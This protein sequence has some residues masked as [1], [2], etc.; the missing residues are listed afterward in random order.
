MDGCLLC[1]A[2]RRPVPPR[3]QPRYKYK[4]LTAQEF[5]FIMAF[6]KR[7]FAGSSRKG[8]SKRSKKMGVRRRF[9][10]G[11]RD[12]VSAT[13]GLKSAIQPFRGRKTSKRSYRNELWKSTNMM[14]HYRSVFTDFLVA[15]AATL[16]NS[17]QVYQYTMIP[18]DFMFITGGA[19]TPVIGATTWGN[20]FTI[21]GGVCT[22]H[23]TNPTTNVDGVMVVTV[24]EMITTGR[25][26]TPNP[27]LGLVDRAWDPSVDF[28]L[29][30]QFKIFKKHKFI[31]SIGETVEIQ[32]RQKLRKWDRTHQSV[33]GEFIPVWYITVS[34]DRGLAG[35]DLHV[36]RSHNISFTGDIVN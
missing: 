22:L 24:Y 33:N 18:T 16:R 17:A 35:R 10:R 13:N 2:G 30:D 29:N 23:L 1:I 31:I 11:C 34:N 14:Q 15:P 3:L 12:K 5:F 26:Q 32:R 7:V 36:L 28:A 4:S 19:Q 20:D 9:S 8:G 27:A 6:R 25:G 21:R